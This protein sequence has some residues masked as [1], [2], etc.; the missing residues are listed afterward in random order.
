MYILYIH[1]VTQYCNRKILDLER[2]K[3]MHIRLKPYHILAASTICIYREHK[4][5]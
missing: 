3:N 2:R 4:N 1:V 5:L